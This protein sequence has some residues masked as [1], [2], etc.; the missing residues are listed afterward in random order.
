M[1]D[2]S[3]VSAGLVAIQSQD[4]RFVWRDGVGLDL[5]YSLAQVEI[6]RLAS[7][8]TGMAS[9]SGGRSST[10]RRMRTLHQRAAAQEQISSDWFE[11]MLPRSNGV[12]PTND[13][14]T[15]GNDAPDNIRTNRSSHQSPPPMTLPA[16]AEATAAFPLC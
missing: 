2:A 9:P 16:R 10:H 12:G 4:L 1:L 13:D 7:S 3:Q 15:A 8:P 6:T 5:Q 11:H 14:R